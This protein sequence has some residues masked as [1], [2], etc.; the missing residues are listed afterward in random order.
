[1]GEEENKQ[2]QDARVGYQVAMNIDL[3]EEQ[4]IFSRSNAMLVA[5]GLLVASLGLSL[6]KPIKLCIRDYSIPLSLITSIAGLLLCFIWCCLIAR[7]SI[8]ATYWIA[9][10]RELERK[11]SPTVRTL[12]KGNLWGMGKICKA[13]YRE[14]MGLDRA[15]K[16][17][18]LV[19]GVERWLS[20][21]MRVKDALY[22]LALIFM[23]VYTITLIVSI[24]EI[25][26]KGPGYISQLLKLLE[27]KP[28]Q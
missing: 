18:G 24:P 5:N 16:I 15:K 9:Q 20:N 4:Q 19:G 27:L 14:V 25:S 3:H 12:D 23:A 1:M 22:W 13:Q 21:R 10:A 28:G 7:T 26:R 8:K 2:D 17:G 11:L 6:D